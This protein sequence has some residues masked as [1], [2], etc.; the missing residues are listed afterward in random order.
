MMREEYEEWKKNKDEV[1]K[2][3]TAEASSKK[4]DE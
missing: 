1:P 4:D 3:A 2:K